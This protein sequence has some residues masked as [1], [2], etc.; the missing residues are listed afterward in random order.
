MR[1]GILLWEPG[2]LQRNGCIS[3]GKMQYL[4]QEYSQLVELHFDSN[5]YKKIKKKKK[6]VHSTQVPTELQLVETVLT[7]C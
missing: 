2:I 4:I 3:V 5:L 1:E 6:K 7:K